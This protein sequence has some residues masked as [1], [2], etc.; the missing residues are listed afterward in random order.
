M[1]KHYHFLNCLNTAS[2]NSRTHDF[3]DWILMPTNAESFCMHAKQR[4]NENLSKTVHA[5]LCKKMIKSLTWTWKNYYVCKYR[6]C[7][8]HSLAICL[9]ITLCKWIIGILHSDWFRLMMKNSLRK[10]GSLSRITV[11]DIKGGE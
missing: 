1:Q 2:S 7:L 8:T 10:V 4:T 3:C 6:T 9:T 11:H 5:Y